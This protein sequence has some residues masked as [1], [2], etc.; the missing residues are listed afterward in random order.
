MDDEDE[1]TSLLLP[2]RLV[3]QKWNER[4]LANFH[5]KLSFALVNG[6]R[7]VWVQPSILT[8]CDPRILS[9][10]SM[11][12]TLPQ[13][14]NPAEWMLEATLEH[15]RLSGGIRGLRVLRDL[16]ID[17]RTLDYLIKGRRQ[18]LNEPLFQVHNLYFYC[19]G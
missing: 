11:C 9:S 2:A 6:D 15:L 4:I 5:K 8:S 7:T 12:R 1:R 16:E 13:E 17:E 3:C 10:V 14:P 19:S 18:C